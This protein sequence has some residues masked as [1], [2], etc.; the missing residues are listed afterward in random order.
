MV[1]TSRTRQNTSSAV[2]RTSFTSSSKSSTDSATRS[3]T[4]LDASL[5]MPLTSFRIGRTKVA[6]ALLE[7][8]ESVSRLTAS[9]VNQ[10]TVLIGAIATTSCVF[11]S[12]KRS[13][14]WTGFEARAPIPTSR[15]V[16]GIA[17]LK[18]PNA[19][20]AKVMTLEKES[21]FLRTSVCA[22]ERM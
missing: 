4:R 13:F 5:R 14:K 17:R 18:V 16:S 7:V 19:T 15:G 11:K 2:S 21:I 22:N 9:T 8:R 10:T 12:V 6:V 3:S 1:K 20:V